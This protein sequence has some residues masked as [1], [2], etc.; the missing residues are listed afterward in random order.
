[1]RNLSRF[2]PRILVAAAVGAA[3][4]AV[5]ATGAMAN[6]ACG[7]TIL[8][9]VTLTAD[10]NCAGD[11]LIVGAPGITVDLGG[12][13]II[14]AG[15]G[16]A[17]TSSSA[18]DV[19]VTNGVIRGFAQGFYGFSSPRQ[20][21]TSLRISDGIAITFRNSPDSKALRTTVT[22]AQFVVRQSTGVMLSNDTL[23]H[24]QLTVF[25]SNAMRMS[26]SA[27][28]DGS[29][30][31]NE[32]DTVK[33]T[34]SS[35]LRN[36]ISYGTVSRNMLIQGNTIKGA[37]E[38]VRIFAPSTGGQ[39]LGNTFTGNTIGVRATLSDV[40]P[41][42]GTSISGNTFNANTAAGLLFEVSAYTAGTATVTGNSFIANGGGTKVYDR[43][44]RLLADGAHFATV[45][46]AAVT[47]GYNLTQDN[48]RYGIFADPG[49]VIDGAGNDSA[50]D[51]LGCTGVVCL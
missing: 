44:G 14:G 33:L 5:P 28:T 2:A 48:A 29:V 13:S 30:S 4:A 37:D 9:S 1:M 21:L 7:S 12:Y 23:D 6:P 16:T 41:V 17:I 19:T 20:T 49:T 40:A 42:S 51:P 43:L 26:L 50:G 47:V 38:G 18:A 24:A 46:G 27:L 34:T 36:P 25:E 31:V 22:G 11:A 45:P 8:A 39:I 15:I 35:F 3:L 32:S 10:L